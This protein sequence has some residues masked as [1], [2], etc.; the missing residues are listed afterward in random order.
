MTTITQ[1]PDPPST[2]DPANFSAE[3]D[4]FIAAFPNFVDE[5]NDFG[6]ALNNLSTSSTST[7][8]VAIGTGTKNFT[9]E[10]GKSYFVGM[11]LKIANSATNYMVGEIISYDAA[12]GALSV[13]VVKTNGSGTLSSWVITL[14]FNGTVSNGQLDD[15]YINDLTAVTADAAADFFAIADTSDTGKKKKALLPIASNAEHVTGTSSNLLSVA[16]ARARNLVAG[17]PVTASGTSVDFTGIPTWV[18]RISILID[19]V[20]TNGTAVPMIQ[21]GDAGG[22]E[23]TSYNTVGASFAAGNSTGI[24]TG[25]AGFLLSNANTAADTYSGAII[26]QL[27]NASSNTWAICGTISK[28][29]TIFGSCQGA[30][31][32]SAAL[33]RIRLTTN[34]GTDVFDAGSIN[35]IYE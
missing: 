13:N 34:N 23:N 24:L 4:A 29:G 35:I 18:K 22:V 7:S 5:I 8:S 17:T 12:T 30:K 31:S 3:A 16:T 11:S 28:T 2:A 15:A 26:L 6:A 27:L 32:L 19:S 25:S 20:S 10:T 1:F 33:D 9:V 14:G 21:L